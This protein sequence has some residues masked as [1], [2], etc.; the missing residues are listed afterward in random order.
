[1]WNG[2]ALK[3]LRKKRGINQTELAAMLGTTQ[4]L[5][6][7]WEKNNVTHSPKNVHHIATTLGVDEEE[8]FRIT[9]R[10]RLSDEDVDRIAAKML[11]KTLEKMLEKLLEKL[12]EEV[13][14]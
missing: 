6:S 5:I 14:A 11:E 9:E 8:L 10:P 13:R 3:G 12:K 4:Q 2:E 1:M 7:K